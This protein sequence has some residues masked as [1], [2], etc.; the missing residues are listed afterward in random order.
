MISNK[1]S[2]GPGAG[3]GVHLNFSFPKAPDVPSC[4][5]GGFVEGDIV[6]LPVRPR[7]P[8]IPVGL[9]YEV[10]LLEYEVGLP[11]T[12]HRLVHLEMEAAFLKL[13]TQKA[14]DGGH[15]C[16]IPMAKTALALTFTCFRRVLVAEK[17]FLA[18][19]GL[20]YLLSCLRG[21]LMT[22]EGLSANALAK[23]GLPHLLT[24]F[25]CS[26]VKALRHFRFNYNRSVAKYQ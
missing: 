15:L 24:D 4:V 11:P 10:G 5:M 12:E 22:E 9:N 19:H 7:V 23:G 20:A 17:M 18:K 26:L 14:L 1:P 16:R 6:C 2:N 21:M 3:S 13:V 25:G 8:I